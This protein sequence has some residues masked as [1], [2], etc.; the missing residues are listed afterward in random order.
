MPAGQID[1]LLD[2]WAAS[3]L[4]HNDAPP[5]TSH[6]DMYKA[7]DSIAHGDVK[8]ENVKLKYTGELPAENVPSWMLAEHEIWYR[9]AK[10][11]AN[12]M[13]ANRDFVGEIDPAPLRDYD[14]NGARQY[15]NF[16]S[17][18]WVWTQAVR[19][20]FEGYYINSMY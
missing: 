11:I 7:I 5:F 1:T 10:S 20:C 19:Y 16:M 18:E 13:L 14:E 4:K 9:N 17:G 2:L 3:L 8:W 6:K 12:N 15:H